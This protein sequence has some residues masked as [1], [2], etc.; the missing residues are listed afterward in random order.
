MRAAH[1]GGLGGC[2]KSDSSILSFP[3]SPCP[4]VV[5]SPSLCHYFLP[6]PFAI[7]VQHYPLAL[8]PSVS[9]FKSLPAL[10]SYTESE[11]GKR[12]EEETQLRGGWEGVE[13]GRERG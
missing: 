9:L 12:G 13:G 3:L 8:P 11:R 2:E 7:T 6:H 5:M 10:W 4:F 1:P